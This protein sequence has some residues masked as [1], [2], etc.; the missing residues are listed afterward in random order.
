MTDDICKL[1]AENDRL[2]RQLNEAEFAKN[3]EF[4]AELVTQGR[5]AP[6]VKAQ[7]LELLDYATR[8]DSGETLDFAENESLSQKVQAFL[9][10]QPQIMHFGEYA[11]KERAYEPQGRNDPIQYAEDTPP[12]LIEL[13]QQIRGYMRQH[14]VSYTQAFNTICQQGVT[15]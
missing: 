1:K 12:E 9:Q 15:Q 14:H 10:N 2:K 4:A 8:Y 13:D 5:L 3:A 7:A 11:T 6:I